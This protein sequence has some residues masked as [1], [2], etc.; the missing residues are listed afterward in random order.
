MKKL[1]P[2]LVLLVGFLF[3]GV[4]SV[5]SQCI[6]RSSSYWGEMVPN[7]GC[8]VFRA[9]SGFGP[10]QYFRMPILQ[11]GSYSISTCGVPYDTQITG[12]QG[13]VTNS[14]IFYNDDNGPIC[15]GLNASVTY[16]PNFT[17]YVRVNVN[18]FNCQPGG[19]S[20][21]PPGGSA[22][23]TV[24]VRQNN[25]LNITSSS[26]S[27]CAG[28]TR[29]LTATPSP[30]G[31][32][33]T[34]SGNPGT[35]SGTGVSGTT[36]TAPTPSGASQNYTITYSFGYCTTSQTITVFRQ[37]TTANAGPNQVV[38]NTTATL[39]GNNPSIG[40]GSWSIISGPGSVSSPSSPTS[41]VTGLV[42]GTSTTLRWTITNGPCGSSTDDVV[43]SASNVVATASAT[44]ILCN[45]S[46]SVVTVSGSGGAA[47]YSGTGSFIRPAGLHTFTVTDANGCS[48]NVTINISQPSPVVASASASA[49]A[50]AGDLSTVT[51]TGSGGT[52]GYTGTGTF[53]SPAGNQTYTITDAN[54]CSD[55]VTI[56]ISQPSSLSLSI[57]AT[58]IL[59]N[60]G[61]SNVTVS[62]SG[63]TPP[64]SGTGTFVETAGVYTYTVTDANGCSETITTMI[65]E[66][67]PLALSISATDILCNGETTDITVSA[68]GG[69]PPYSGTGVYTETA[70]TYSYTVTDA[71]GC[72]ETI[73]ISVTEPSP[74]AGSISSTPILCNGGTSD[75]TVGASGGTT[76]Y[77]GTGT[78]TETAGTY[79]YTVT[80][81]NGCTDDVSTTVSDPSQLV[82]SIS[83]TPILCNGETTSITVS[84]AGGTAPYTG[85][86]TFTETAGTY[87]Y[88]VTDANGC[89]ETISIT[90]TEPTQLVASAAAA[91]I[92]CLGATTDVTV[93]ATGG[94]PPYSGIGAF[95]VLAGT[96]T[97]TVTDANGCSDD[98]TITVT[99]DD[100]IPPVA[101]C[102]D[103]IIDLDANGNASITANDV[104]NG[105]N[106]ACGIASLS[107]DQS[108]FDCS[109]VGAN[110]VTLTVIDNGGNSSTCTA[111]VTVNDNVAPTAVCQNVVVDL[112][113]SG[114]ASITANDVDNGSS[115]ACGIA[116]LSIS[117]SSFDCSNVGANTVTLT[118]VDNNGNS[119]T[120]DATVTVR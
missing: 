92:P 114:N 64:Y 78:F 46:T 112:D 42:P 17:D 84:A 105:S 60:G 71:N 33:P 117:Q 36:F 115:D 57:S 22:S 65:M 90:V 106:D 111:T 23:I 108:S 94:T 80:D 113:A 32:G 53:T 6:P 72:T 56:S 52:P 97:Y 91:V 3:I 27:M 30:V 41:S 37:P 89:T 18:L 15:T 10:G 68:S 116:S 98:V 82:L 58:N 40:T 43:L 50:C 25:N 86:G 61:T 13:T 14:S 79:S 54:G 67:A 120:C 93:T 45:G 103:L 118:V 31:S 8:G 19:A 75:I 110:T 24:R 34:N 87:T 11:G 16:T 44:P 48:D 83:S 100:N 7:A 101:I 20:S 107:I 104:D 109:N 66:P 81:G 85:T 51:V 88:T 26:A 1:Y 21:V 63:G 77:T 59:C 96:Y 29:T 119:S 9:F 2:S 99:E 28:Q 102:Q 55:D 35:F 49:I 39:A 73:S 70:G 95:N 38:C 62:A 69:T 76:P 5:N 4:E 74:L 12:F 47:P